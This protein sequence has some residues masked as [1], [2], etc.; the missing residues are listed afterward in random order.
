MVWVLGVGG[1]SKG[2]LIQGSCKVPFYLQPFLPQ[3]FGASGLMLT[4]EACGLAA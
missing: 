4:V 3:D 1:S 2:P